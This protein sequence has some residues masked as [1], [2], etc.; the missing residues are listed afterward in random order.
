MLRLPFVTLAPYWLQTLEEIGIGETMAKRLMKAYENQDKYI[1]GM[2]YSELVGDSK[3]VQSTDMEIEEEPDP[4][5]YR[6]RINSRCLRPFFLVFL[7]DVVF[8]PLTTLLKSFFVTGILS[9]TFCSLTFEFLGFS[10]LAP[11]GK[12]SSNYWPFLGTGILLSL[13]FGSLE[14]D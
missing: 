9:S 3:S 1:D 8:S 6:S 12:F 2:S 10:L 4:L 5:L 14:L 13:P 7:L 11:C